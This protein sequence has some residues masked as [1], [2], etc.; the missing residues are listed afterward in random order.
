MV[1]IFLHICFSK[2]VSVPLEIIFQL[3]RR[4]DGLTV[5]FDMDKV[6]TKNMWRPGL[7]MYLHLVKVLE[8][9]YPEMMKRMFVVNGKLSIYLSVYS[10]C[11]SVCLSLSIHPSFLPSIRLSI[12]PFICLSV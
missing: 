9:N 5:I 4:V 12:H 2:N 8:D 7:Q 10:V 3:G 1:Y 6:G 11:L